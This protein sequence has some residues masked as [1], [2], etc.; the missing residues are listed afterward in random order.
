MK[1]LRSVVTLF[2]LAFVAAAHLAAADGTWTSLGPFGGQVLSL[3]VDP[4][5]PQNVF[6]V[7]AGGGLFQSTDGAASW[8][9]AGGGLPDRH[10]AVVTFDFR[11]PHA[12][13]AG[14]SFGLARSD[15]S[16]ATWQVLPL[17]AGQGVAVLALD[18]NAPRTLYAGTGFAVLKS[19]DGGATWSATGATRFLTAG[20]SALVADSRPG[21][22]Y[23]ATRGYGVVRSTDGGRSWAR[24]GG[25]AGDARAL[26]LQPIA[27][28][29]AGFA[30]GDLPNG[31]V[32]LYVSH[33]GGRSWSRLQNGLGNLGVTSLA[34][35]RDRLC[36]GTDGGGVFVST[37]GGASWQ[38]SHGS[39]GAS[40]GALAIDPSLPS[41]LY[42]GSG[43]FQ[44]QDAGVR[45]SVDTG[46]TWTV[47]NEGLAA[48]SITALAA[49]P[50]PEQR[51]LAGTRSMGIFYRVGPT[52]SLTAAAIGLPYLGVSSLAWD[53]S[54][55]AGRTFFGV[56]NGLG[57]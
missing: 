29:Y 2:F 26:V 14:G 22:V 39:E 12:L 42:A 13:Y 1:T 11:P 20:I 10:V 32:G 6:A 21:F 45:K 31:A 38:P 18:P 33:N 55:A 44:R 49:S 15:D 30:A 3:A 51:L 8:Q 46:A 9:P 4:S 53:S 50:A 43:T 7:T 54:A 28:V 25:L 40:V 5:R 47:A 57:S 35:A 48:V 41:T 24:V 17:P 19:E 36:A 23:A 52:E 37:D 27:T 56:V 34:F 16:G